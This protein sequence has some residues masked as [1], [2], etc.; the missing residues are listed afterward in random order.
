MRICIYTPYFPP[1]MGGAERQ[2]SL[3]AEGLVESGEE[4][5]VVTQH[6]TGQPAHEVR[7]GVHI[8][9]AIRPGRW[10]VLFGLGLLATLFVFFARRRGR[11][12]VVHVAGIHLGTYVPCRLRRRGDFRV[13]LRPM[14][15]GP[16]GDLGRLTAQRFWPLWRGG[17]GPTQRYLLGTIRE[18]DAVVALNRDLV[19]ELA[20]TGFPP[21][22]IVR[23]NNGIPVP[24]TAWDAARAQTM[25][26]RLGLSDG[27]L[28]LCV[29]R[30]HK[31][32]GLD[33]LLQSLA[34]LVRRYPELSLLLLG[35]GPF[36]ADLKALTAE[37]GILSRVRFLGFQ[38]PAPYLE[39]ADIFVLPTWGE[40]ISNAL[41]EAMGTGLPCIATRVSGNIEVV[42]HNDT[43]LLVEPGQPPELA[44]AVARLLEDPI[45]RNVLGRNARQRVQTMYS[46]TQ[47]V[48]NYRSLFTHLV[49]DGRIPAALSA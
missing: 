45:L 8:H 19:A 35:N 26:R 36:E 27:P 4:V 33:A 34:L 24:D 49:A 3:L 16:L 43:G 5:A 40:G 15:P 23:I 13:V 7:E 18:A 2:A 48:A 39:A 32:K 42:R 1:M 41:L 17:D 11:F 46:V 28:L 14:G 25:R 44:E 38:D 6:L 12:D 22:R 37:L 47:M 31:Q 9:R 10:G 29:G 21:E 20:A 30:L